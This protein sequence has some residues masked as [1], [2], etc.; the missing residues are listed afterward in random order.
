MPATH[1]TLRCWVAR[2]AAVVMLAG[3]LVATVAPGR[4]AAAADGGGF[5][6]KMLE[7]VNQHPSAAGVAPLQSP[8]SLRSV[9]Q[10]G[11]GDRY[12]FP[13]MGRATDMGGYPLANVFV[14]VQVFG[15]MSTTPT[16]P[17]AVPNA[18]TSLGA[19][20]GNR[21]VD[22]SWAPAASSGIPVFGWGVHTMSSAVVPA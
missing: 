22:V 6:A 8:E 10:D 3:A 14:G 4:A 12:G 1:S 19:T 16:T 11:G 21:I 13:V 2:L 20:G 18:P 5:G 9:V 7:L 15:R 17:P